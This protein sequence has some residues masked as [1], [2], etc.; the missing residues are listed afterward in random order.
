MGYEE[1]AR[2]GCLPASRRERNSHPGHGLVAVGSGRAARAVC[3][4]HGL[5][6]R[7]SPARTRL[8]A[9]SSRRRSPASLLAATIRF[10]PDHVRQG[11]L[12]REFPRRA[13]PI[14]FLEILIAPLYL[15]ALVTAEP[16]EDWPRN[17]L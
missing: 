3:R 12:A 2:P 5:A 6:T 4:G 14:E 9:T 7:P 13:D 11:S 10:V 15:R 8:L 17:A 1:R 16:L